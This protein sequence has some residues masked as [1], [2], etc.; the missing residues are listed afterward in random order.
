MPGLHRTCVGHEAVPSL[1][2]PPLQTA[3]Q[4]P[5]ATVDPGRLRDLTA[6][7]GAHKWMDKNCLNFHSLTHLWVSDNS[8]YEM[9]TKWVLILSP[10]SFT[11]LS[12]KL[13]DTVF[14]A[15]RDCSS[16]Q[17]LLF[18]LH[19]SHPMW[20]P[21]QSLPLAPFFILFSKTLAN[22][23]F[24]EEAPTVQE[25]FYCMRDGLRWM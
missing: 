15:C 17:E 9:H 4:A 12:Y 24:L 14:S 20:F 21:L 13:V 8:G 11:V 6:T 7:K 3:T 22:V 1:P 2:Q 23:I 16:I 19:P 25:L 5:R 10:D 18:L